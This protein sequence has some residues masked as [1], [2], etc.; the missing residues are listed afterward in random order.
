MSDSDAPIHIKKISDTERSYLDGQEGNGSANEA[1][2]DGDG[3]SEDEEE[4][5]MEAK[6]EQPNSAG[7]PKGHSWGQGHCTICHQLFSKNST[8]HKVCPGLECQA[9][10]KEDR[11]EAKRLNAAKAAKDKKA[12]QEEQIKKAAEAREDTARK[13][14]RKSRD[15]KQPGSPSPKRRT[16]QG[17][18]K[19]ASTASCNSNE[20]KQE[21]RP[22]QK[23]SPAAHPK[24][25]PLHRL[26]SNNYKSSR[27]G[28]GN[29]GGMRFGSKN[30]KGDRVTI[31]QVMDPHR[32]RQELIQRR[33]E[34]LDWDWCTEQ[35]LK[36]GYL[37]INLEQNQAAANAMIHCELMDQMEPSLW[38]SRTRQGWEHG[39]SINLDEIQAD[40]RKVKNLHYLKQLIGRCTA[41]LCTLSDKIQQ[42]K[43]SKARQVEERIPEKATKLPGKQVI[44]VS[45][46]SHEEGEHKHEFVHA[47]S[48]VQGDLMAIMPLVPDSVQPCFIPYDRMNRCK[49]P[50][51]ARDDNDC[52][53]VDQ[54][55]IMV[56]KVKMRFHALAET[57]DSA[58]R[59]YGDLCS[60]TKLQRGDLLVFLGD[61][62]H[63]LPGGNRN[64]TE[65]SLCFK[66]KLTDGREPKGASDDNKTQSDP[67]QPASGENSATAASKLGNAEANEVADNH[68]A[69]GETTPDPTLLTSPE[70]QVGTSPVEVKKGGSEADGKLDNSEAPD[71]PAPKLVTAPEVDNDDSEKDTGSPAQ[72]VKSKGTGGSTSPGEKSDK[73]AGSVTT[74]GADGQDSTAGSANTVAGQAKAAADP[75][76]HGVV[77]ALRVL[78]YDHEDVLEETAVHNLI[79][80]GY[81]TTDEALA[82]YKIRYP[83]LSQKSTADFKKKFEKL[84]NRR[85]KTTTDPKKLPPYLLY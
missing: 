12:A 47:N 1:Y 26:Q 44:D 18:N 55:S 66:G 41:T 33:N 32:E 17:T 37:I 6:E 36:R 13:K 68:L 23:A 25:P 35:L 54:V 30:E 7:S 27:P 76:G 79:A 8:N 15:A 29:D 75:D 61:A 81:G 38:K 9:I 56:E 74:H 78:K 62:L 22:G 45:Y 14:K 20:K 77:D 50:P 63:A 52:G 73:D 51:I 83:E 48:V 67:A 84:N 5:A 69:T 60:I 49:Q 46:V 39:K 10:K 31:K 64:T 70:G 65:P 40:H 72:N 4:E 59:L 71:D 85:A 53:G 11:L 80:A 24:G 58:S 42:L 2:S 3:R 82:V 19:Q 16:E 21:H 34:V 57:Y 43:I 28:H